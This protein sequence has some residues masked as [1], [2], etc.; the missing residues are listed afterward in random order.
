MSAS[1]TRISEA[2]LTALLARIFEKY[3][4]SREVA[5]IVAA[6]CA[7]CER[8]GSFSHGIF[9]IPGYVSTLKSGWVDGKAVP[10][11]EEVGSTYLRVDAKNGFTQPAF[12]AA[13]PRLNEMVR[14]QG[15]GILA[16]R[17][18]QHFSALWPDVEPFARNGWVALSV[19]NSFACV[20][21]PGGS[22][23]VYGTNPMAFATPVEGGDPLVF[24]QAA[25]SM[26]N[27]DVRIAAREGHSIPE[28][29][30]VDR[31]GNPTTDP[32]AVLDGGALL[33]FGGHKG[34]SI[35]LM[36][37]ILAAALTG[38]NY[39]TEVDW[40]NHPG[41]E[42]P[43]T[44]QLVIVIDPAR[45]G[46]DVFASRVKGLL[47]LVREAGQSRMPGDRRYARRRETAASGIPIDD[48]KLAQ[49]R[50]FAA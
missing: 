44:G 2:D 10:V 38:G 18:S 34:N 40:S 21:P 3:G 43:C 39:S 16:I 5:A 30:G 19:V 37:E 29:Y 35:A 32:K 26:A 25:S 45:G 13:L 12:F 1:Q 22:K 4:C 47:D 6:N 48:D 23:P 20:V 11:V 17:N 14:E 9:R 28:G 31:N 15:V 8:D 41:A 7:S 50:E 24:D 49:L 33:P 27:G 36:I 46:N 42:V